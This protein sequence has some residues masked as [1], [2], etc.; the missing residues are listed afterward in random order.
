MK[1]WK[2]TNH[3][4]INQR[5]AGM[6]ILISDKVDFGAKKIIRD[7]EAYYRMIK[8]SIQQEDIA[9]LNVPN[10]RTERYVKQKLK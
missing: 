6:A 9:I 3:T 5:K 8:G 1:G 4:N 2:K 10:D 7:R